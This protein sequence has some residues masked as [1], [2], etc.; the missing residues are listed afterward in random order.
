MSTINEGSN[1]LNGGGYLEF[2]RPLARIE[3]QIEELEATQAATGRDMSDMIRTVRSE[4]LTAKR[5]LYTELSAWET[6]QIARHPKRPLTPDYLR[7][8]V[9]DFVELHGDKNFRDD[10]AL[11]T[12]LGRIGPHKAMFIGHNKG[13]DTKERIENCFGMAHPE[14]YRKAL[15]KMKLAEKFGLPIVCLIDTAGAYPGIGAEERGIAYAIAVNLMEMARLKV[16][17]SVWSSVRVVQAGHLASVSVIASPCSS[18]PITQSSLRRDAQRSSGS[19]PSTLRRR[20]L[21]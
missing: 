12:G 20:P 9:R 6:V 11:I 10:R 13:K 17:S 8:M 4:L 7:L 16:R 21:L 14:G 1:G 15:L 3:K 18:T 2:E 19:P 5:R